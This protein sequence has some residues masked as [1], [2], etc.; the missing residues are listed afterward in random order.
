MRNVRR[1]TAISSSVR[2]PE[3]SLLRTGKSSHIM[4]QRGSE[5]QAVGDESL[6][7]LVL[8]S[9]SITSLFDCDFLGVDFKLY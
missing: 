7:K 6:V 9:N 3:L 2:Q 4:A 8:S 5:S 1:E